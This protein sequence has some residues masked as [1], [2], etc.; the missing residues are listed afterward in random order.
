[1]CSSD[2]AELSYDEFATPLH[3]FART[4]FLTA[5]AVARHMVRQR[6]GVILTISTIGSRLGGAG[7]LGYAGACATI[8][9]LS[10]CLAG[11]LGVHGVRTVCLRGDAITDALERGSYTNQVFAKLAAARGMTPKALLDDA[12]RT[13]SLL[14]RLPT[15]AQ[16]AAAAQFAASDA[17]GAMTGAILNLSCG[18]VLDA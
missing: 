3:A 7:F 17:A 11:E 5:R 12:A 10:R 1:M 14:G 15:L 4:N 9:A 6:S 13:R 16:F 18:S 8:E 2:L